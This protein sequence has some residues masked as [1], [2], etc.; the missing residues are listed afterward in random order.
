MIARR[1]LGMFRVVPV[2]I[3]GWMMCGQFLT[4]G[5]ADSPQ[6]EQQAVD[7]VVTQATSIG[8]DANGDRL[9]GKATMR[10]GTTRLR[11]NQSGRFVSFSKDGRHVYT[12]DHNSNVRTW[13]V[14]TG[15]LVANVDIGQ[16]VDAAVFMPDLETL[17]VNR[18]TGVTLL[19]LA[20]GQTIAEIPSE[21]NNFREMKLSPNGFWLASL[22]DADLLQMWDTQSGE[23]ILSLR[24]RDPR[25][26]GYETFAF[27]PTNQLIAIGVRN[28][29]IQLWDLRQGGLADELKSG[30]A[31]MRL[32]SLQFLDEHRLLASGST[33]RQGVN[34]VYQQVSCLELWN[35]ESGQSRL[36]QPEEGELLGEPHT[37]LSPDHTRFVTAHFD[38]VVLWDATTGEPIKTIPVGQEIGYCLAISPNN[39]WLA[40]TGRNSKAILFNLETGRELHPQADTHQ[41]S[42]L[43][44]AESPD[45]RVLVSAGEAGTVRAWKRDNGQHLRVLYRN[46]GW[47]NNDGWV[48][49]IEFF[50]DGK[51]V[52]VSTEYYDFTTPGPS[53]KGRVAIVNVE[54][55]KVLREW[56]V[57]NRALTVA[58]SADASH[59]AFALGLATVPFMDR[60]APSPEIQ[61]WNVAKDQLVQTLEQAPGGAKR[62]EFQGNTQLLIEAGGSFGECQI[63]LWKIDQEQAE[64]LYPKSEAKS[65]RRIRDLLAVKDRQSAYI[66][67]T[68]YSRQ[69]RSSTSFLARR[70][71]DDEKTIWE[72]RYDGQSLFTLCESPDGKELAFHLRP[73]NDLILLDARTGDEIVA[74][75]TGDETVRSL[76]YSPDGQRLYTG[77]NQGSII[78]WDLQEIRSQSGDF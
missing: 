60:D 5:L 2:Y 69:E 43:A 11:F 24:C 4:V 50:P 36:L 76:Q 51:R 39:R 8:R 15:A 48:R 54:D 14:D 71:I 18:F 74:M 29:R 62:L 25:R 16:H 22:P 68:S 78:R 64:L 40:M 17:L 12:A 38:V 23:E 77:M 21:Q 67:T 55:G 34:G 75:P 73:S 19:D 66:A 26:D 3:L 10:Y 20:S 47:R 57:P 37:T 28:S 46:V 65:D 42:V 49:D 13:H 30:V 52:I 59:V 72:K 58:V 1:A 70:T 27:S 33:S 56:Q 35:L 6:A 9:P 45:G 44:M 31:K 61:I 63:L 41:G 7:V 32:E 53:F